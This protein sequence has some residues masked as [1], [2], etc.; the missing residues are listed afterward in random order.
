MANAIREEEASINK[1]RSILDPVTIN[2]KVLYVIPG[3]GSGIRDQAK[4]SVK[5]L[6]TRGDKVLLSLHVHACY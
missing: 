3:G 6:F 2:A 5:S 4:G 1:I